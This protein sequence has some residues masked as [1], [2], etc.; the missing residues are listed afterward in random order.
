VS[1]CAGQRA[2]DSYTDSVQKNFIAGCSTTSV[3]PE[4]GWS[5]SE[6]KQ[7]CTCAYNAIKKNVKFSTFKQINDDLTN[8]GGG[9][10]PKS[11]QNAYDSC[12]APSG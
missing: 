10:L 3:A 8:S 6:A 5:A 4:T 11:F 2:P 1:G 12:D 7:Y 9:P